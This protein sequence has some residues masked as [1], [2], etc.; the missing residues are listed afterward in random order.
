MSKVSLNILKY[1]EVYEISRNIP[2][3]MKYPEVCKVSRS[4]LEYHEVLE[5]P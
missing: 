3:D 1:L 4:T 5:L 2:K